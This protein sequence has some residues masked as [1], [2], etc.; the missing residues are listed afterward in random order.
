M[1]LNMNIL[2]RMLFVIVISSLYGCGDKITTCALDSINNQTNDISITKGPISIIG[3]I[4][5]LKNNVVP[6]QVIVRFTDQNGTVY[7]FVDNSGKKAI[8]PGVPGAVKSTN[9][10][11]KESG[12]NFIGDGT[13]LPNGQY[14]VSVIFKRMIDYIE[15]NRES[16]CN[17]GKN[18]TV[19]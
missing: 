5:D 13:Q 11:M 15:Y 2:C 19:K 3:W 17:V 4:V 18:V 16:E 10:A 14:Q 8:R 6:N 7:D 9:V 1:N 12:F